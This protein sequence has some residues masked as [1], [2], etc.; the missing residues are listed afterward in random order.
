MP[1]EK[2]KK[3][4]TVVANFVNDET[5][6]KNVEVVFKFSNPESKKRQSDRRF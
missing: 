4:K 1:K 3:K 2:L 5:A 6:L